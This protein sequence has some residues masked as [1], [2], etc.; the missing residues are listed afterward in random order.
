MKTSEHLG[1]RGLV[2]VLQVDDSLLQIV[3]SERP[4]LLVGAVVVTQKAE[5]PS[6]RAVTEIW[7]TREASASLIAAVTSLVV[8][9]S[10]PHDPAGDPNSTLT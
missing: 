2:R 9:P 1:T 3:M 4:D 10:A 6:I 8:S 5:W 7:S